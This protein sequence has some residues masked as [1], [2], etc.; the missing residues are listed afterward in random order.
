MATAMVVGLR[1]SHRDRRHN[2]TAHTHVNTHTH[3]I[4]TRGR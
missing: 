3:P 4:K 2:D 1:R